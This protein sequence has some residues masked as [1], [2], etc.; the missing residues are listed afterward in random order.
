MKISDFDQNLMAM[1]PIFN[2]VVIRPGDIIDI[3]KV[4]AS[5]QLQE[6]P[7]Y[8]T[9]LIEKADF[10]RIKYSFY[11]EEEEKIV[12]GFLLPND[13]LFGTPTDSQWEGK[14]SLFIFKIRQAII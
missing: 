10:S 14:E 13:V 8:R 3:Y 11:S 7:L 1:K 6:V 5:Y 2:D 9:G 12:S 4:D